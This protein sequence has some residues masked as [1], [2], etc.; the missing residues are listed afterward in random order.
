MRTIRTFTIGLALLGLSACGDT[1]AEQGL[2]GAGA[3]AVTAKALDADMATGAVV[4]AA[5]NIAYCQRYPSRC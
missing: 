1:L 5:G 2:I 3:G 4:G